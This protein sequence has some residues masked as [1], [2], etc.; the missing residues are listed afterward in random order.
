M[1]ISDRE[2]QRRRQLM[3]AHFDSENENDAKGIIDTFA[4]NA[5]MVFN[6][7]LFP[8]LDAIGQAHAYMGFFGDGAFS[9][10]HNVVDHEYFTDDHIVAVGRAIGTHR[11]EFQG[12]P[13]TGRQVELPFVSFYQFDEHGKLVSERVV[14]NLGPLGY[15]PSFQPK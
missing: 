7:Q 12:F 5:K 15:E 14:M 6:G 4:S 8:D 13:P 2:R 3:K 10:L 1:P 9:D 11:R